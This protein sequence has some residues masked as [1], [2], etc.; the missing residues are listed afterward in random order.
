MFHYFDILFLK[1]IQEMCLAPAACNIVA[2]D[3][4]TSH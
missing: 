4:E 3:T 2:D 1:D